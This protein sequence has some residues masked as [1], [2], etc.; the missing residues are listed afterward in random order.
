MST[1]RSTR[2]TRD[3][4]R[5][6]EEVLAAAAKVFHEK[7]YASASIQDVAEELDILKGSLYYYIDS[8]EDLLFRI[9][10][11]VHA[12][13]VERL[14]EWLAADEDP[15]VLLRSYLEQQVRAYCRDVE[16]VGVF[17]HDFHH[18][19]PERQALILTE[20]D[21]FD[22]ALRDLIGR[23]VAEGVLAPDVDPKLTAMAVFGM[24]N[25]ISTWWR[26]DGPSAPDEVAQ[27]FTDLVLAGV[28][29][30]PRGSRSDLGRPPT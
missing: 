3:A 1:E 10:E 21:R 5:R 13:I 16:R 9:I 8:K 18:L 14:E 6:R 24:M 26:E 29:G 28:V 4:P 11:G 20:R 27:Q 19:S 25:W 23:G 15:L 7:G 17:L 30:P 22:Q 12:D 2:G